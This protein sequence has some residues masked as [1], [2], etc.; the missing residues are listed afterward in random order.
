MIF[1]FPELFQS[2]QKA[3]LS[4]LTQV[5]L[6]GFL[7]ENLGR[8][9]FEETE[10]YQSNFRAIDGSPRLLADLILHSKRHICRP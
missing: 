10:F 2:I 5:D 1:C 7:A 8:R 3:H 6:F 9:E 4:N